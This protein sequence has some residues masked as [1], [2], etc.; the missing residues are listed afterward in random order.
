[1]V[2]ECAQSPERTPVR[3]DDEHTPV[4]KWQI[5]QAD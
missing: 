1:M 3:E 5:S 2:P 4:P